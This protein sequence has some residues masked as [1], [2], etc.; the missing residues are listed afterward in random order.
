Y[1][2][3]SS[4]GTS[5]Y[6]SGLNDTLTGN[7]GDDLLAGSEG[8]DTLAGGDGADQLWG[9]NGDDQLH[10]GSGNDTLK[11]ETGNDT[12]YGEG[13]TNTL[14]GGLG[15]DIYYSSGVNDQL[16][17]GGGVDTYHLSAGT[18][19]HVLHEDAQGGIVDLSAYY[20]QGQTLG[21]RLLNADQLC[22][23]SSTGE[24]TVIAGWSA[25]N[26]T[27]FTGSYQWSFAEVAQ[28]FAAGR[29]KL[30]ADPSSDFVTMNGTD[31]N[32]TLTALNN[33]PNTLNGAAGND[34][35]YG[36]TGNDT[37]NGGD[38]SDLLDGG[39]GAD[40]YDGGAGN[41]ILGGS[42]N[43]PDA[44]YATGNNIGVGNSY[45]GGTGNDLLRGTVWSD[46]Y[47]FNLGDGHD[48]IQEFDGTTASGPATD[49]LRFGAGIDPA[50]TTVVR[51]GTSL[52]FLVNGVDSVEVANWYTSP[53]STARQIEQV[54]F[55]NGVTWQ[56][57]DL[58][59]QGLTSTG[60]VN[61]DTL[62]AF[63]D[64]PN[65]IHAGAG[66]DTIYG[67]A[68]NDIL[69]GEGG[70][71][72]I[73]GGDGD[74]IIYGDSMAGVL[75]GGNGNDFLYG[76]GGNDMLIGGDGSD[77]L[78]GGT[79]ADILDGG[80]GNDTL[81]GVQGSDDAGR[82][83]DTTGLGNDYTGGT[84]NDL[85]RGTAW[86][87]TY[88]F[89]LGDGHDLLQ[90]VD[91][92]GSGPQLDVLRFGVG[93][94][95]A[96]V[97]VNRSGNSLF[98]VCNGAD[99]I[100]IANWYTTHT[101]NANQIEQVQFADG[102]VWTSADLTA[103]GLYNPGTTGN[104]VM[105]AYSDFANVLSGGAGND[106]L[107]AGVSPSLL[108]GGA[109]SDAFY[110]GNSLFVGGLDNDTFNVTGTGAVL[111]INKGDGND[112]VNGLGHGNA[113]RSAVLSLGGG[114]QYADISLTRETNDL[115]VHEGAG[116]SRSIRLKDWYDANGGTSTD[117]HVTLQ[118]IASASSP[119]DAGT[120]GSNFAHAVESFD[121]NQFAGAFDSAQV[122]NPAI[123]SWA[124]AQS[125]VDDYVASS[126]SQAIGGDAAWYY[127]NQGTMSGLA[128]NAVVSSVSDPS[129]VS[130]LAQPFHSTS[131]FQLMGGVKLA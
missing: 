124:L 33:Y 27:L 85:L 3:Q 92:T 44:G 29:T 11:G 83:G 68:G 40:L 54:Q 88:H 122:A 12:L 41:D 120:A 25:Q 93:I 56:A 22:L 42:P 10:G 57:A 91:L 32:D 60:T 104:D 113:G 19:S 125:M 51:N 100:E 108:Y 43:S 97:T 130:L 24:T 77:L 17:G 90:E 116:A 76:Q 46:S 73:Y 37:L 15:D 99:S 65:V 6:G 101:S 80:T 49:V 102:T 112:A 127:G 21:I 114:L 86:A 62:S 69:Y 28:E 34:N 82:A 9:G 129:F 72:T 74:D 58:T 70:I 45:R 1:N 64:F 55:A 61:A 121:F 95:P 2:V 81:G 117:A 115:I 5:V 7:T 35:L 103:R 14:D 48:L 105:T 75:N 79:G 89:N 96:S 84:G 123:T 66:N 107:T 4:L 126:E 36:G 8:N 109:G 20:T 26:V 110:G 52:F 87:D 118:L 18:G 94:T 111:A 119:F 59:V 38:G 13:G 53:G 106:T 67:G 30:G 31:N 71:D 128:L 50:T 39:T 98:L 78:D 131:E 63:G 47:T 23:T 16:W